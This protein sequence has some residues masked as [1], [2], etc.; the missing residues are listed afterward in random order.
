MHEGSNMHENVFERRRFCTKTLLYNINCIQ[1][2][3]FTQR[4]FC[5]KGLILHE[6]TF[7]RV[8]KL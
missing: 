7:A 1:R 3:T 5:K 6:D 8:E 2:G 4:Q